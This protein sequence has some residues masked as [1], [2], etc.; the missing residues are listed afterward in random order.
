ME[1]FVRHSR[2]L[3][4]KDEE[5]EEIRRAKDLLRAMGHPLARPDHR[6]ENLR[7]MS[8]APRDSET[9]ILARVRY[10][11]IVIVRRVGGY[12]YWTAVVSGP[13]SDRLYTDTSLVG[14]LPVPPALLESENSDE[15]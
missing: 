15:D 1:D 9:W 13:S 6:H 4:L 5:S 11:N 8:E 10:G 12:E 3:V 2:Y 14:W 7:P